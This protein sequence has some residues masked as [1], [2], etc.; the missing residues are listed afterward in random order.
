M[1]EP[2]ALASTEVVK[3][4][5][6]KV[7]AK[8][9]EVP[10]QIDWE[11]EDRRIVAEEAERKF[12]IRRNAWLMMVPEDFLDADLDS[13]LANTNP[14]LDESGHT[15]A[16]YVRMWLETGCRTNLCLHGDTDTGKTYTAYALGH[17]MFAK[18]LAP[19]AITAPDLLIAMRPEGDPR[20][21]DLALVADV[22]IVDDFGVDKASEF[23]SEAWW[24]VTDFRAREHKSTVVTT[25]ESGATLTAKY[26]K[27]VTSRLFN[28]RTLYVATAGR[29]YRRNPL[30]RS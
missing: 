29:G 5:Q 28:G 13:A 14:A 25:N 15:V 16:D 17:A 6:A 10:D 2:V 8:G 23:T 11:A 27:R 21:V 7:R 18:G 4:F 22:L 20:L 26:G 9:I 12:Q 19:F 30:D 24:R 1:N 3:E